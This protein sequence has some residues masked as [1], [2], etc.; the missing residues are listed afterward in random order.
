MHLLTTL[1]EA[2]RRQMLL[3][4]CGD[5]REITELPPDYFRLGGVDKEQTGLASASGEQFAQHQVLDESSRPDLVMM[6]M[7]ELM[8]EEL[9]P[10][11]VAGREVAEISNAEVMSRTLEWVFDRSYWEDLGEVGGRLFSLLRF[12]FPDLLRNYNRAAIRALSS[13]RICSRT[14]F[15]SRKCSQ[16]GLEFALADNGEPVVPDLAQVCNL[17]LGEC[18]PYLDVIKGLMKFWLKPSGVNPKVC[19]PPCTVIR[20]VLITGYALRPD[21]VRGM[22]LDEL[23]GLTGQQKTT[24]SWLAAQL[25]KSRGITPLHCR[26]SNGAP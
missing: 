4:R 22:D 24:F 23:A 7:E 5:H 20:R 21:L 6:A 16:M 10:P 1:P 25:F 17:G 2:K 12:A 3:N 18:L 13:G 14:V 8:E 26:G 15:S 19:A 11:P 9:E